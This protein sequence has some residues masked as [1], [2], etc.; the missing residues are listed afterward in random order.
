MTIILVR[1]GKLRGVYATENKA[2]ADLHRKSPHSWD[3]S[4][5]YGGWEV[6]N[7]EDGK[8]DEKEG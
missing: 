1:D 2:Y 6:V 3:Y 5:K 7:S 4:I 8:A